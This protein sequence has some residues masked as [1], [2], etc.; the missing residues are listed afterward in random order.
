VSEEPELS[1]EEALAEALAWLREQPDSADAH[2]AAA[3][4]YEDLQRE[5]ERRRELLEVLRLDE[6]STTEPLANYEQIICDEVERTLDDLP[7]EFG[8]RLGAVTILVEP[9]PS[10]ALVEDGVDPRLLGLFEGGTSEELTLGL[11]PA[12]PSRVLIF[13]HNL[14]SAFQDEA[15]LRAEVQVTVLHEIGHFF[16][17]EEDDMERLGLQ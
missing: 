1:P 6:L 4:A 9:R 3:L 12:T 13:A 15:S 11:S 10:R 7:R 17:L 16:G 5:P 2:Y 14:A 8:D